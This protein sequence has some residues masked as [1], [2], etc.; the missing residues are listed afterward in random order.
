MR[1][2]VIPEDINSPGTILYDFIVNKM[3]PMQLRLHCKPATKSGLTYFLSCKPTALYSPNIP[4]G[5][6]TIT[7]YFHEAGCIL[8]LHNKLNGHSLRRLM[9]TK[10]LN[11][12][13][14]LSEV[15]ATA[16]H[17]SVAASNAYQQRSDVSST[18]KLYSLGVHLPNRF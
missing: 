18:V 8:K 14:M 11:G 6:N 5:K 7:T 16:R 3:S 17:S 9:I 10:M 2:P 4:L 1:L 12:G 13:V 15:M